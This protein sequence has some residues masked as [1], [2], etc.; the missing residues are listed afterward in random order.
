MGGTSTP[1]PQSLNTQTQVQTKEPWAP[2]QPYLSDIFGKASQLQQQ[3][4]QQWPGNL[5]APINDYQMGG[6]SQT[7]A[8]A[9]SDI[10]SGGPPGVQGAI[11]YGNSMFASHGLNPNDYQSLS[12]LGDI[13]NNYGELYNNES[14]EPADTYRQVISNASG[15]NNPYLQSELDA[16]NRLIGNQVNA[17]MSGAGRYGSGAHTDVMTRAL[18]ETDAPILAQDYQNRQQLL[19]QG[20]QGLSNVVGQRAG[21]LGGQQ[22]ATGAQQSIYDTGQNRV[23]QWASMLPSLDAA[24]YQP[25]QELQSAGDYLSGL[26]NQQLQPQIQQWNM[27]QNQAPWDYLNNQANILNSASGYGTT[28]GNSSS[29]LSGYAPPTAQRVAGGAIAGAGLGSAFGAFGAPVGAA[30]GGL[31]GLL[32]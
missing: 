25:M 21:L 11:D 23:G 1:T 8:L 4:Y 3:G 31:L 2:A 30:A 22:S 5:V 32:H 15:Q 6:A 18:S 14:K 24:R 17:A 28:T 9:N 20:A 7:A 26:N 29:Q 13:Y 27:V 10:A 19:G 16:Q 12:Q